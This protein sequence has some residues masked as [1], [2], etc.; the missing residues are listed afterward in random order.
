LPGRLRQQIGLAITAA[1]KEHKGFFGQILHGVL[2]RAGH[3]LIWLAAISDYPV[4]CEAKA[5]RRRENAVAPVSE[6]VAITA[7][8][9]RWFGG[10]PI[11]DDDVG[12]A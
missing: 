12:G 3:N 7:N 8:W 10:E 11:G 4:G 9:N 2:P 6:E 1:Q 5:A